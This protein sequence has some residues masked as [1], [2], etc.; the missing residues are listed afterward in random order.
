EFE[1]IPAPRGPLPQPRLTGPGGSGGPPKDPPAPPPGFDDPPPA[2]PPDGPPPE[3]LIRAGERHRVCDAG[4]L[5]L[6]RL[7]VEFY[8]RGGE[9]VRVETAPAKDAAG[10]TVTIPAIRAV[11]LPALGRAL[12]QAAEWYKPALKKKRYRVDCPK[13]VVEQ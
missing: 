2:E 12:N 4:L 1:E 13:P 7:G 5:A 9:L 3:I 8:N 10:K 6:Y 11:P